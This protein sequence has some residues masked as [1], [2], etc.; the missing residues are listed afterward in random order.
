[1]SGDISR[2]NPLEPPEPVDPGS[3]LGLQ[4]AD[5]IPEI[6]RAVHAANRSSEIDG[7]DFERGLAYME[8]TFPRF[9]ASSRGRN[10]LNESIAGENFAGKRL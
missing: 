4:L 6:R 7:V 8:P 3:V 10:D 1:M 5:T 2:G 9:S